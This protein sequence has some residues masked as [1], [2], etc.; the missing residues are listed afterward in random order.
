MLI[1]NL[2]NTTH[3]E[4]AAPDSLAHLQA[5]LREAQKFELAPD[6]AAAAEELSVNFSTIA[7]AI[8]HCRLP[9][10]LM[11]LEVAQQSRPRFSTAPMHAPEIQMIPS[12]VGFLLKAHDA[13]LSRFEAH[14]FWTLKDYA[15]PHIA[16]M[17]MSFDP[18]RYATAVPIANDAV[19]NRALFFPEVTTSPG[20][21]AADPLSRAQIAEVVQPAIPRWTMIDPRKVSPIV[22]RM[23]YE[24]GI[25]D[26]SGESMFILAVLTLLNA[27]NA[28]QSTPTD[29]AK[30]NAA[31][32]RA[33]KPAL[34]DYHVL[35]IHPRLK[36]HVEGD[37]A[38]HGHRELRAHLVR[39]HFKVRR[40]G[41]F[42]WR[43]FARGKGKLVEKGYKVD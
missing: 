28:T 40:S 13:Q 16:E 7:A 41:I 4:N 37:A 12:R 1:D 6:F 39:G 18:R 36:R 21:L 42:F 8:P 33:K 19:P 27:L 31:R 43:P 38:A 26:W 14:Q 9:Y 23:L 17:A 34:A 15:H 30:L 32:A 22:E 3:V 29:H 25:I 20:W 2:I 5:T 24:V 35:T 10:P 11:W